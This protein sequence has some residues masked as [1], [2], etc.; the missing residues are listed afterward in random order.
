MMQSFVN[1][2]ETNNPEELQR[3]M[4]LFNYLEEMIAKK[5]AEVNMNEAK[6][7]K[8]SQDLLMKKLHLRKLE[9]AC[10]P[11]VRKY[12]KGV[13]FREVLGS[14]ADWNL[15]ITKSRADKLLKPLDRDLPFIRIGDGKGRSRSIHM[16]DDLE[17]ETLLLEKGYS[18][19]IKVGD[20]KISELE[21]FFDDTNTMIKACKNGQ[22][23]QMAVSD[24]EEFCQIIELKG[25]S[26]S[27][28]YKR[29]LK[30]LDKMMSKMY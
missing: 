23:V 17:D 9:E 8:N 12:R 18:V 1:K 7:I 22:Q 19:V 15:D 6:A 2:L 21:M 27:F 28:F 13:D 10:N 26:T 16:G 11:E 25:L 14:L 24:L 29:I 5:V 4:S 3:T 20:H 30:E